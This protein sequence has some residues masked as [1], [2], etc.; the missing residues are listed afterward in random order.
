MSTST[1]PAAPVMNSSSAASAL[2]G[3]GAGGENLSI[4]IPNYNGGRF[5]AETIAS[6]LASGDRVAR[7]QI[8]VLDNGSTDN[9]EAEVRRAGGGRVT[10]YRHG[11]NLGVYG[12]FNACYAR[13][14]REWV[15]ILHSDDVVLPGAM[16]AVDAALQAAPG[17]LAVFG[18]CVY[19][20]ERGMWTGLSPL[21][22]TGYE[23]AVC[24]PWEYNPLNWSQCV[25]Q[26][27]SVYVSKSAIA[28]VGNFTDEFPVCGDWN[29]WWRIA[30]AL[31]VAFTNA[32]LGGYRNYASNN[33]MRLKR[34]GELAREELRLLHTIAA[35][36]KDDPRWSGL[37]TTALYEP[38][39][40]FI[41]GETR[42]LMGEPEAWQANLAVL[43]QFPPTRRRQVRI[44]R[45]RLRQLIGSRR[46][47]Q[48]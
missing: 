10:F 28:R 42:S 45:L 23:G 22:G 9:S 43:G 19:T 44:A 11:E 37:D 36:L 5:I 48:G 40:D 14:E 34:S 2:P 30:R 29:L 41:L 18:R 8:A 25:A 17:A 32:C 27:A 38:M 7:A 15:Q 39:F 3:L 16:D 35:S 1:L 20:D 13:A 47:G 46:G 4:M 31:P 33:T 24:G 6:V 21:L 12:N 26:F